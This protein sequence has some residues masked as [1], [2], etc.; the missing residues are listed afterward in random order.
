LCA[1]LEEQMRIHT[2]EYWKAYEK[3]TTMKLIP[4]LAADPFLR[5]EIHG[6]QRF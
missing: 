3:R 6:R 1:L 2:V 5:D 4:G